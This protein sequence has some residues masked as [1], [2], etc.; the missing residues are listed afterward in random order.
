[1]SGDAVNMVVEDLTATEPSPISIHNL[2][3]SASRSL[4]RDGLGNLNRTNVVG[5]GNGGGISNG[6]SGSALLTPAK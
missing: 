2:L 4:D 3:D 5:T 6:N 1:M